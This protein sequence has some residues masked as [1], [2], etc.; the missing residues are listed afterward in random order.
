MNT[1]SFLGTGP[2]FPVPG[3][4]CSSY[5]LR[6]PRASVLVDAGEPCSLRL[7]E[8]NVPTASIDSIVITHGHSDHTAG[9]PMFLQSAWLE[10]R[11]EKL[12]IHIPGEL[13]VPLA[14]W[15]DACY[16]PTK[17]IGFKPDFRPWEAGRRE[18]IA[19]G[20]ECTPYPTTHLDGL[21]QIINPGSSDG[22]EVFALG[23]DCGGKRVVFSADLGEPQ[24][25]VAALVEPCDVLVC[26][27]S[28]YTPE[29]LFD[30]LR[31]RPIGQLAI[32]H[33]A[34]KYA[35]REDNVL[36]RARRALPLAGNIILPRDGDVLE[37]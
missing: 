2:G 15:L 12:P 5:L 7:R 18:R 24:D 17:L 19:P 37:F 28:H 25:L 13:I 22:F 29:A 32:T 14:A 23:V 35:G 8:M 9:L 34:G 21:R 30:F 6:T 3:R 27:L 36:D 11:R 1:I 16:L 31:D 4:G 20:V 26:E 33:L 10:Q